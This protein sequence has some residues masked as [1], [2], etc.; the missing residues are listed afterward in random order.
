MEV[1]GATN[2]PRPRSPGAGDAVRRIGSVRQPGCDD[3]LAL[4][5]WKI[6]IEYDS[7]QEHS[8]EFQIAKDA[9]RRNQIVAAGYRPLTAR[10]ADV[11]TGG[12]VFVDEVME[13]ARQAVS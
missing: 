5:K 13:T 7:K 10:Y 4:P 8:D 1:R 6:T 11:C 2:P 3:D 9:R 12:R